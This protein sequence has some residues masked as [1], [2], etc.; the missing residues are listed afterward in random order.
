M[1]NMAMGLDFLG[2]GARQRA[3][4]IGACHVIGAAVGGAMLGG[5]LGWFGELLG[6]QTWQPWIILFV[7]AFALWQS[8]Y[9]QS[10]KLGRQCQVNRRWKRQIPAE[11]GYFLWGWQ[12]G[13]GVITFIPYSCFVVLLGVQCTSGPVIALLSGALFGGVR[14]AVV[15]AVLWQKPDDQESPIR[16]VNFLP[17]LSVLVQRL[18][19]I[20]LLLGIPLLVV[21]RLLS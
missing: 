11:L 16:L 14:E 10:L 21:G 17:S 1:V 4:R 7:G 19:L 8:L 20:W 9:G 6:I 5:A 18:N 3:V 15:L 13:C 12:L 2:R